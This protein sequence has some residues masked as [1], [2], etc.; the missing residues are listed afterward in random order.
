MDSVSGIKR[1]IKSIR[2]LRREIPQSKT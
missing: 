1:H 2:S